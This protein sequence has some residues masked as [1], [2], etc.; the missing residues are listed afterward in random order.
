MFESP[1]NGR[2]LG[3]AE[4]LC[5]CSHVVRVSGKALI[6]FALFCISLAID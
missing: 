6:F 2:N 5:V 1:A 3:N 4:T